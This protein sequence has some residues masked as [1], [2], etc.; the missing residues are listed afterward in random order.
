MWFGPGNR[1][2]RRAKRGWEIDGSAVTSTG[3]CKRVLVTTD[4]SISSARRWRARKLRSRA[5]KQDS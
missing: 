2:L 5:F 1:S 4:P 3:C